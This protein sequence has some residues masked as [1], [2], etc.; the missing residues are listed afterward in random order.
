MFQTGQ[1]DVRF[2]RPIFHNVWRAPH[3]NILQSK[4]YR[5]TTVQHNGGGICSGVRTTSAPMSI[6][7]ASGNKSGENLGISGLKVNVPLTRFT[8][9]SLS[10][11]TLS[12]TAVET[13]S[14]SSVTEHESEKFS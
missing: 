1:S 13:L 11:K 9:W 8:V 12:W 2:A 7:T 3:V 4:S 6:S 5:L 10:L 14:H